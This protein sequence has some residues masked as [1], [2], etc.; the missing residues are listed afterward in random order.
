MSTLDMLDV[1]IGLVFLYLVMSLIASAAVEVLEAFLQFRARDLERGVRELLN[2]PALTERLYN[3]PLVNSLYKG[4]YTEPT[5]RMKK[6]R[7]FFK[8]HL[9]SYIPSRNFSLALMDL[10]L[11]PAGG[12]A[13]SGITGVLA[14]STPAV[15]GVQP[16]PTPQLPAGVAALPATQIG[17]A[18]SALIQT[19]NN[20]AVRARENVEEWFNA[21]MD[22]VSGWYKKRTQ[23]FLLVAGLLAAFALNVDS[24][25][26]TQTLLTNKDA[27]AAAVAAATEF[28][29]AEASNFQPPATTTSA[30]TDADA[31]VRGA[32]D[33]VRH[34]EDVLKNAGLPILWQPYGF[35]TSDRSTGWC[36]KLTDKQ[37]L[38]SW[39]TKLLGILITACAVSL[40]APFWFD[41]LNKIIVVRSTVKPKEKSGVEGSKEPK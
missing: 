9:P 27:R 41:T 6:F 28:A 15:S 13:G 24:V 5:G 12:A 39:G 22:R 18:I 35:P 23:G 36:A 14:P 21:S 17:N 3:H 25:S 4:S 19:A 37:W 7:G 11:T 26:I 16:T 30:K 20:D 2:D 31:R 10:M 40:G 34:Y 32:A 1:A 38:N 8:L 33:K 29:K